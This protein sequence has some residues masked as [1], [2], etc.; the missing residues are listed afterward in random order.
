MPLIPNEFDS[1]I[2]VPDYESPIDTFNSS[3]QKFTR[4]RASS[5]AMQAQGSPAGQQQQGGS[6]DALSENNSDLVV[7]NQEHDSIV[8]CVAETQFVG[9]EPASNHPET[10]R[11]HQDSL[12]SVI[13]D[14]QY[15]PLIAET[16][17]LDD[18][19]LSPRTRQLLEQEPDSLSP[20]T[21]KLFEQAPVLNRQV[22]EPVKQSFF[23][24]NSS[25]VDSG[26]G[27]EFNPFKSNAAPKH[28]EVQLSRPI[29]VSMFAGIPKGKQQT[30]TESQ[31]TFTRHSAGK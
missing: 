12:K 27:E 8:S 25:D 26:Y 21:R 24:I 23:A 14:T 15:A 2:V 11:I 29:P 13:E 18:E 20:R 5:P 9:L 28:T 3:S 19:N 7:M 4:S 10:Q 31:A 17:I 30:I 1:Q 6:D 22:E 16:Q